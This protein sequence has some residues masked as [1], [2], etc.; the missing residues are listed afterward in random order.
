[1]WTLLKNVFQR[2]SLP[3][4]LAARRRFYTVSMMEDE[5][6]LTY[7]NRVQQIAEELMSMEKRR[8]TRRK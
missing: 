7:I 4:K 2:S 8:S 1:M 5:G 3:N 6:M